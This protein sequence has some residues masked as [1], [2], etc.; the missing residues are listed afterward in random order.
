MTAPESPIPILRY[1]NSLDG[2]FFTGSLRDAVF[3]KDFHNIIKQI[4]EK[5]FKYSVGFSIL[6]AQPFK[7][8]LRE[9]TLPRNNLWRTILFTN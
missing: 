2:G 3:R 7:L 6:L 8:Y 5:D 1:L 4:L 9:Q